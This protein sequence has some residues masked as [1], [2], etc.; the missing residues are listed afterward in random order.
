MPTPRTRKPIN[1]TA[2][3]SPADVINR[4][5]Y[6]RRRMWAAAGLL[7]LIVLA[8]VVYA[9]SRRNPTGEAE[10]KSVKAQVARH[11]LLPTDEEPALATITDPTKLTS[12]LLKQGQAGDRVLIYQRNAVAIIYRPKIDRIIA[13]G[14]VSIDTP[15]TGTPPSPK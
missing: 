2:E 7:L 1:A 3:Y 15:K 11:Y 6:M 10:L 12:K 8:T 5:W 9:L 14:P 13:V 4:P